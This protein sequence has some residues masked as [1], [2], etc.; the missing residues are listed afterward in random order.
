M[1]ALDGCCPTMIFL[2]DDETQLAGPDC[3]DYYYVRC[4]AGNEF[5]LD[6]LCAA[7]ISAVHKIPNNHNNVIQ[8]NESTASFI[9]T[10]SEANY[11][12]GLSVPVNLQSSFAME[13]DTTTSP[14]DNEQHQLSSVPMSVPVVEEDNSVSFTDEF[15]FFLADLCDDTDDASTTYNSSL[16]TDDD[17]TSRCKRRYSFDSDGEEVTSSVLVQKKIKT[18]FAGEKLGQQSLHHQTHQYTTILDPVEFDQL[19]QMFPVH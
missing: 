2:T 1:K 9:S 15:D 18:Q 8:R 11:L 7:I 12:V 19:L 4:S 3:S 6:E 13:L 16:L 14:Y 5:V 10:A 17:D